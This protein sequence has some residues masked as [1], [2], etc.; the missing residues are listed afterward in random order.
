MPAPAIVADAFRRQLP[1]SEAELR[2]LPGVGGYTAAAIAA[3]AF[4]Q[5]ATPVDGNIERVVARLFALTTPL[6]AAKPEIKALAESLTPAKRRGRFRASHDGSWRHD[7]HAAPACLRPVSASAGLRRLRRK[8]LLRLCPIVAAKAERPVRRGIAF[9]ALREDGAVLL[10]ERP[11]K[12]LLGGMSEVPSSAWL[13][14]DVDRQGPDST[15]RSRWTGARCPD[16]S[17]TP[18][19]IS[20]WS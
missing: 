11:L 2:E 12:G 17:S 10:R 19:P 8:A 14:E 6:P 20:I 9:V 18:S 4:G 16:W 5:R 7:L 1:G 13:S 15:R 3:I